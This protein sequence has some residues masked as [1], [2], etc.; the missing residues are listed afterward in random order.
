MTSATKKLTGSFYTCNSVADYI[1]NWAIDDPEQTVLEPS[2]GDGIFLNSAIS[3]FT[4]LGNPCPNIIGVELQEAPFS[5]YMK[6]HNGIMGYLMDFMDYRCSAKVSAIIGNPPYV[7]LKRLKTNEREKALSLMQSY[8]V[9]MQA[10]GSLWMPF[11]IHST[12]LLKEDGKL[13]FVLP[14]EITHVKYA[15]PLWKYLSSNFG[16]LTICRVYFDFFPDV[17]VETIVLLAEEKGGTTDWIN[18]EV[19]E[20]IIDL[21]SKRVFH[22]STISIMDVVSSQKPFERDLLP[23]STSRIVRNMRIRKELGKLLDDCKFKIWYVSGNKS[24]F[25]LTKED[26]QRLEINPI[27]L[28]KSLINSK[29]IS[30]NANTGIETGRITTHDYLFYPSVI[31]DKEKAYIEQGEKQGINHGYK[32]RVRNPWYL[33]PCLEIPELVLTVF[34]DVPKLL[35]NDGGFYV[36]NSLLSGFSKGAD[37]EKEIICRWYNSLTLLSIE[38]T[39]HSLG[40]G[41]LVLIPGETDRLEIVSSFPKDKIEDTYKK[42]S[43]FALNNGIEQLYKYGDEIVLHELYGLE[44]NEIEEIRKAVLLYRKWRNPEVRRG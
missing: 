12:E 2:F 30:A 13:G 20:T 32:C 40:G 4:A 34:G 24:F 27:N 3:R 42:L 35:L 6:T 37:K 16:K 43:A 39:I 14:Y 38:T 10:S 44:E 21:Y 15:Y 31:G 26:V 5:S 11:V 36:S 18:Y 7:R 9:K 25:N 28:K 29:Q 8:G 19:Y 41:T 17:D 22:S 33:T 1:A 23:E